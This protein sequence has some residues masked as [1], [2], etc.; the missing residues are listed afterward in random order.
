MVC[1]NLEIRENSRDFIGREKFE[2][3]K[4]NL[5]KSENLL[6]RQFQ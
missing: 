4:K 1:E 6:K 3:R 2:I 5:P